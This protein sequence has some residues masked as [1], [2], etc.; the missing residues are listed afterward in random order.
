MRLCLAI[1]EIDTGLVHDV[2]TSLASYNART[3]RCKPGEQCTRSP[4]HLR[5]DASAG[6][7]RVADPRGEPVLVMRD[8]VSLLR[9][10]SG[11]CG[12]LAAA[13]VGWLRAHARAAAIHVIETGPD[14]WHVV[15]R[16]GNSIIDPAKPG[17]IHDW[18]RDHG[19]R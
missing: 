7:S 13:Y 1:P 12:E 14:T 17:T 8:A 16:V 5:Y 15:A 10:G 11:A 2:C 3:Y 18:R 6:D 4:W 19:V 9:V